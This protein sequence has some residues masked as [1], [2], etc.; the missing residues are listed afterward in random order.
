MLEE[1]GRAS[2]RPGHRRS[3]DVAQ[4]TK[5]HEVKECQ[6]HFLVGASCG[7]ATIKSN[8]WSKHRAIWED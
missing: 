6:S 2:K 8:L 4:K 7:F 5:G 1:G 3:F